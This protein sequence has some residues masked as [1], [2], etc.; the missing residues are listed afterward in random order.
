MSERWHITG[1]MSGSKPN[2][3]NTPRPDR[4]DE[5]KALL[6]EYEFLQRHPWTP[7]KLQV[8][9]AQVAKNTLK[10]A[11]VKCRRCGGVMRFSERKKSGKKKYLP[12]Q[13]VP[14]AMFCRPC[15]PDPE[16]LAFLS[17]LEKK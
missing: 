7:G 13:F 12:R 9:K 3:Q 14:Y 11:P 4:D 5:L 15:R 2:V 10:D 1:R 17:L 6:L 8:F 16:P